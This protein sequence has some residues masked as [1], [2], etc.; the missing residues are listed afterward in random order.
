MRPLFVLVLVTLASGA[1]AQGDVKPAPG[2]FLVAE[3]AVEGGP[4]YESVVLLLSHDED[5]TLGVIVN[6]V[7]RMPLSEALPDLDAGEPSPPLYF[8]G[9]VGLEGL[10]ILFRSDVPPP[11]ADA[12][13]EDVYYSGDRNVLEELIKEKKQGGEV[14]L[15]VGHSGWAAGQLDAELRRGTWHV[16]RADASTVF[17]PEPERL[18]EDLSMSGRTYARSSRSSRRSPRSELQMTRGRI[19]AAAPGPSWPPA[20]RDSGPLER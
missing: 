11:N 10:L 20:N 6:R 4:F 8:G 5:G 7:T 14:R 18:W 2:V 1:S 15:F 17:H 3:P 16:R 9:P 13:M 19:I 12:V